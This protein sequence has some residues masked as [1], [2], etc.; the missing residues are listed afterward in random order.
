MPQQFIAL[1]YTTLKSLPLFQES[2]FHVEHSPVEVT[3][4]RPWS[5]C[6]KVK[7]VGVN[8]LH[9][10]MLYQLRYRTQRGATHLYLHITPDSA[11]YTERDRGRM[12]RGAHQAKYHAI[13][14][15]VGYQG[16]CAAAA[17]R[18]GH[19]QQM[20]RFKHTGLA[21]AVT[22]IEHIHLLQVLQLNLA[23]ISHSI[24]LQTA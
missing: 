15:P 11:L 16:F 14:L 3:S 5:P 18:A 2:M 12:A 19:A 8:H 1:F 20:Y 6:Q 24:Y 4:S 10:Q 22:T 23:K 13:P 9:G 7:G 17:E 21:T